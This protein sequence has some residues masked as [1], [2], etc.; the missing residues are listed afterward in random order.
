MEC[1]LLVLHILHYRSSTDNSEN[2]SSDAAASLSDS[3]TEANSDTILSLRMSYEALSKFEETSLDPWYPKSSGPNRTRN[4]AVRKEMNK[5]MTKASSRL[6]RTS[7]SYSRIP[8][9]SKYTNH[10][11]CLKFPEVLTRGPR[12]ADS[13]SD[14]RADNDLHKES[15][16]I[17][18][19]V[20]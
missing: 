13:E 14:E 7:L 5:I 1:L 2:H 15:V 9:L 19:R 11:C 8:D 20:N 10:E 17:L 6:V 16:R 18:A 4:L 12:S 3:L